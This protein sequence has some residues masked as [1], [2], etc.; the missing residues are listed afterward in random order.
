MGF[1][2]ED[3]TIKIICDLEITRGDWTGPCV[4]CVEA[5]S[6]KKK[7]INMK[8][9][10]FLVFSSLSNSRLKHKIRQGSDVH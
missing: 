4:L 9:L 10:F 1:Y 8:K 5:H 6:R 3:I 7:I 2:A